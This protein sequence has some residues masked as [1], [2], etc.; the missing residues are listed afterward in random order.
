M[1]KEEILQKVNDFCNEKSYTSA[2]LTDGFKDKFADHFLK[3]NK[4]KTFDDES[5]LEDLKFSISTA[6]SSASA[7]ITDKT[8]TFEE[9]E[10][11]Y[12]RQIEELNKKIG[13]AGGK[14][15][16]TNDVEPTIPKEVQEQLDELK[17][18]KDKEAKRQKFQD[19]MTIAKDGIRQDLHKSFETFAKGIDVMLDKD[20][21]EQA[22][23]MVARFQE[24]F[25]DSIG[26][27]KPLAP[28][29]SQKRDEDFLA[30]LPKVKVQ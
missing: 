1:E 15:T 26:D 28:K 16:K 27:I 8:K 5:V 21:K 22:D 19:I 11:D 25:K 20:D 12:K 17:T 13:N 9:R 7:I 6:F 14:G 18:F 23:A 24:I 29:Q 2:T 3:R 30:S 4:D 10:N